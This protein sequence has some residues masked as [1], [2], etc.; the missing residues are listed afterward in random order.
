M[1]CLRSAR[2]EANT[3]KE[4]KDREQILGKRER[5]WKECRAR[6]EQE[7]SRRGVSPRADLKNHQL[8]AAMK[9]KRK[10]PNLP[11]DEGAP[12]SFWVLSQNEGAH[13][14]M[15][16]RPHYLGA[17]QNQQAPIHFPN[18]PPFPPACNIS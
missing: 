11:Q 6:A 7:G 16:A 18:L 9:K 8:L 3:I 13:P 2:R 4:T 5:K 12:P 1:D 10:S 14:F 15:R 17:L